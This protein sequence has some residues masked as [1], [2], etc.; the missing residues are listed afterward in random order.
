MLLAAQH[1]ECGRP[2]TLEDR[3]SGG[4][5]LG[6]KVKGRQDQVCERKRLPGETWR[7][8]PQIYTTWF[9]VSFSWR[10]RVVRGCLPTRRHP[11][12]AA[13]G[14]TV[15]LIRLCGPHHVCDCSVWSKKGTKTAPPTLCGRKPSLQQLEPSRGPHRYVLQALVHERF[16]TIFTVRVVVG[17]E[18]PVDSVE[19]GPA[20]RWSLWAGGLIAPKIPH[21]H[22][23]RDTMSSLLET[24]AYFAC[25]SSSQLL[26]FQPHAPKVH[27]PGVRFHISAEHPV[28]G[29]C[30]DGAP[31][32]CRPCCCW[33]L[34]LLECPCRPLDPSCRTAV[35][36]WTVPLQ[37]Q[38][39]KKKKTLIPR[40]SRW[41]S[42]ATVSVAV[43]CRPIE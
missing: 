26:V 23:V 12:K 34:L 7:Q 18:M 16:T 1:G 6:A 27:H 40:W 32:V 5:W 29:W 20:S 33:L 8:S 4:D 22:R 43:L 25:S 42:F 37:K 11:H 3:A 24:R 36:G 9:L 39:Q 19:G 10:W 17:G 30:A 15:S 31:T 14:S 38:D 35:M 21:R 13:P 2:A 41:G 28:F